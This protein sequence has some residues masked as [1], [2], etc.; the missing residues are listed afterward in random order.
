MREH[1]KPF[2]GSRKSSALGEEVVN[3]GLFGRKFDKSRDGSRRSFLMLPAAW[4]ACYALR[5]GRRG[6][7]VQGKLVQKN[8]G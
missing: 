2:S 5:Q 6:D 8:G 7:A 1:G 4:R 3:H